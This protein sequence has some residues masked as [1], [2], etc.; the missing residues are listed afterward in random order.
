MSK[1]IVTIVT[2]LALV[3]CR[4]DHDHGAHDHHEDGDHHGHDGPSDSAA[5]AGH[6]EGKDEIPGQS[7][8]VWT[9]KTELFIEYRPLIVGRE[10][11]FAAHVTSI[12]GFKAVTQGAMTVDVVFGDGTRLAASADH[13][14]SPGIFR[15]VLRPDKAGKCELRVTVVRDGSRDEIAAGPCEVFADE[16]A[17][18]EALGAEEPPA[19]LITYLK[20][21]QWK[22]G[23]ATSE[24]GERELQESVQVN[25]EIEPAAGK[26][27]RV[28]AP[29]AGRISFPASPP[30]LGA[31]VGRDDVLA[32][33]TPYLSDGDRATLEAD[34]QSAKAEAE[35][36]G[37]QLARAER[38]FAEQAIARRNVEEAQ[39]HAATARARLQAA[40]GRLSQ[41]QA[42]FGAGTKPSRGSI[43]LR[44]PIAG[45]LV[46]VEVASGEAVEPG[47]LLFRVVDLGSVWLEARV[48]E[49]DIAK[50]D[51]AS[52]GS[53]LAEGD[54][55]RFVFD[56]STSRRIAIGSV[57]DPQS[58]T[59]P[60]IFEVSNTEGRLRIGQFVKVA[61]S[62]GA[63]VKA[64]AVPETAL[65]EEAGKAIAYVQ[66]E[67]EAFERRNVTTGIR[68]GGWVQVLD[69]LKP[70]EHVVT[71][72]AYDIKLSAASGVIPAHGHAH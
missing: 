52:S 35:A 70:G 8:T 56:E 47:K 7:V 53:F 17:A 58:R 48:F 43:E 6:A 55:E 42:G 15:P 65:I 72:G 1:T 24:V 41:Y 13:A 32:T 10:S 49:P 67:G 29:A 3:G 18:R 62:T 16:K 30:V 2:A 60:A 20:E 23:F 45:T 25:G 12:P 4:A 37:A 71:V 26:D 28:V 22:T 46:A 63:R 36:A 9:D 33:F 57:I 61:I 59:V 50:V 21:Q 19:G 68:Q 27:A 66:V 34:V 11:A 69:G 14:A 31:D 39:M 5:H 40:T 38:L 44:S 54:P 64:I 51:R